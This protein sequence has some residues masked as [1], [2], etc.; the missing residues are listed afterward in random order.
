MLTNYFKIAWRNLIKNPFFSVVNI[1]GLSVGIAFALIIASYIWSEWNVNR[2]LLH[3]ER[4][5]IIQSKWKDPN[6]GIELTS[7]GPLAKALYNQYP[8]LVKNYYRWDGISSNVSL[9]D[10]AFREGLQIGDS[11]MLKMYGFELMDGDP[12]T[13]FDGPYSLVITDEK[14]RKYFGRTDVAGQSLTIENFAGARHDFLIT[15]VMKKPKRNSVSWVTADNDN[16]FYISSSDLNYFGR[17]METWLNQY[18][19]SYLE[20]Q[21]GVSPEQLTVPIQQLITQNVSP[22]IA[23]NVTTYLKPLNEYYLDAFGGLV[24]KLIYALGGIAFFILL[25]AV[26]NFVNLSVSRSATRLR[27]IGIRKVMGGLRNQLILQ[28][29]IESIML[30]TI[31]AVFAMALAEMLRPFFR[32][33]MGKEI[34]ALYQM[35]GTFLI[36]LIIGVILVGLIAGIYPAFILSAMRSVDS[37]KGKL[38]TVGERVIL[39][40]SLVA[41]QFATAAIVFISALIISQ[42]VNYFF[43]KDLGFDKTF[44]VSAQ[45]PRNWTPQGVKQMQDLRAQF[46]S[47]PVIQDVS[48]SYE[49]LDGNSSGNITLYRADRDSSQ[50]VTSSLLTTDQH[51][52]STYGIPLIAGDFYAKSDPRD[53]ALIVINETQSKA[54][55]WQSP[56]DAVGRQLRVIGNPLIVIVAGVTK[57]FNFGAFTRAI[58]PITFMQVTL[59]PIYRVFSFKLKPGDI[60][61]SLT[62]IQNKWNTLMPGAPFEYSF[63]DD[64][65]SNLY[66]TELQ[67]KKASYAATI[68]ALII[69]FLGVLGLIGLSIQRRV[70]EIGIR[71]VLGSSVG[72]IMLLFVREFLT[73]V[74]FAGI[75]A[76]PI[77]YILM[78]RWLQTY[79]YRIDMTLYPFIFSF[80]ALVCFTTLLICLQTIKVASKNPIGSL[81]AE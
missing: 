3:A 30:T 54:L 1:A 7:F 12:A 63:M 50:A 33:V 52:I 11:T 79:V 77:A 61:N 68:L 74:L 35:P 34:P 75:I 55:G 80:G 60:G 57:D 14:A 38:S 71:K 31:A 59:N 16:Q 6:Q 26:I 9:G 49:V 42:Q 28:F 69:V 70:K 39:R 67:L 64:K 4:Q 27:E 2:T 10:K 62:N 25:M 65:L 46:A 40:K 23:S 15:G 53:S 66:L 58:Q 20:L 29:L 72:G 45:L 24:K 56:Q 21:P 32:N 36:S 37:L 41:F 47:L 5:Y 73:I 43:K 81:R 19:H 18:I 17:D 78:H 13:A 76:S 8:T 51:F 44:I 48:L 22:A